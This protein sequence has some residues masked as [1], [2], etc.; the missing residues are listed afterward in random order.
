MKNLFYLLLFALLGAGSIHAN[1]LVITGILTDENQETV[2]GVDV[3]VEMLVNNMVLETWNPTTDADGS[4][5]IET[6]RDDNL[7]I[8]LV[9]V[10][11]MDCNGGMRRTQRAVN[12]D[13]SE[14]HFD[15][16]YCTRQNN[17]PCKVRIRPGRANNR[18]LSLTAVAQG[19]DP[20][21]YSW[22]TGDTTSMIFINPGESACVTITDANG[23]EATA[24]FGRNEPACRVTIK[25]EETNT[26]TLLIAMG[27]EDGGTFMWSNGETG[28]SITVDRPGRYC[29]RVKYE[30]GCKANACYTVRGGPDP[31]IDAKIIQV[32]NETGDSIRIEVEYNDTLNL[33]FQWNTGDTTDFIVVTESGVYTVLITSADDSNCGITLST[34]VDFGNCEIGIRVRETNRGFLLAVSP[35]NSATGTFLWSTGETRPVIFVGSDEAEYCVTVTFP[36]CIAEACVQ[37]GDDNLIDPDTDDR[38]MATSRGIVFPNPVMSELNVNLDGIQ[39]AESLNIFNQ[40]GT[41]VLSRRLAGDETLGNISLDVLHLSPGV[42]MIQIRGSEEVS[43]TRFVK[44]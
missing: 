22:S 13:R 14:V 5:E 29:V 38:I 9:R 30:N 16:K 4:F 39:G 41:L 44:Q 3:K 19:T 42:Y 1:D 40:A 17:R 6:N 27:S 25:A 10:T 37:V 33:N 31:C 2:P 36:N 24:C 7:R 28:D 12:Q 35:A 26:G 15:L 18:M 43:T 32:P 11:Y 34:M 20:I 8:V 23:C 21:S